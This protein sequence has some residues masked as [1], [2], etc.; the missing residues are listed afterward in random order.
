MTPD[1]GADKA[2]ATLATT[3]AEVAPKTGPTLKDLVAQQENAIGMALPLNMD[4]TRFVRLVQTEL[5]KNPALMRCTPRSFLGAVFT[6]AQL[7]LEFGPLRQAY[8]IPF[9][10]QG[11]DEIQLI[12][13]YP[14]WLNLIDRS[15]EIA[16]VSV[17]RVHRNDD[18]DYAYGMNE[19]LNH[20]PADGDRGPVTH[21]YCIIRKVNGGTSMEVMTA[22]EVIKHRDRF[23]KSKGGPWSTDFEAMADKTVFLKTKKWLPISADVAMA[24]AVDNQVIARMSIDEDPDIVTDYIDGEI[25]G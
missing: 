3:S 5:S 14:G 7:G 6:A 24:S 21:Y 16:S 23:A 20:K 10:N 11:V 25:V 4:R 22:A 19:Y 9:K 8:M 1:Q 15:G 2:R 18:F 13:G 12:I 17:R